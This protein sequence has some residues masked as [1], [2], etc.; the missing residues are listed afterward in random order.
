MSSKRC[1]T[2]QA[3]PRK[4]ESFVERSQEAVRQWYHRLSHLFALDRDRRGAI[5]ETT[6]DIDGE[7]V[8]GWVAIDTD[9]FE[10]VHIEVSAGRSSL[11]AYLF[12]SWLGLFKYRTMLFCYRFPV[13]GSIDS[14]VQWIEARAAI[15]NH[16]L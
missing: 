13:H 4:I 9:T 7:E 8:F 10:I 16:L 5:D 11:D 3:S 1:C 12:Q 14:T 2:T 6:L 15:H